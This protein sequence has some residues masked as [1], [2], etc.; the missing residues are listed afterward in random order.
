MKILHCSD[1]HLGKKPFGTKGFSQKRYLD[2]FKAFDEMAQIA[3]D[4]DVKLFI[5]AGDLF[6]KKELIPDTLERC[7]KTF[8]KLKNRDIKVFLIEGNHDNVTGNEEVNSWLGYLEKKG[9]VHRGKY[10]QVNREYSFEKF[11]VEDIN[12]YGLGY[13]GFAIDDVL[14]Q[15]AKSLDESEKNIVV[16]HT[17]LGGSEYL[18]GLAMAE[19]IRKLK[20]KVIYIAGGHLHSYQVY[21]KDEPYFF[22]PGSLEYWN[23]LNE[24][25]SNKGGIIFDTESREHRFVEVTPRKRM[26]LTFEYDGDIKEEFK[27]FCEELNLTGEELVILNVRV[28]ENGFIN[29]TELENILENSGALR[30]FIKLKYS[31]SSIGDIIEELGYY[32][33]KE[34]EKRIIEE[35]E[36]FRDSERTVEYL[37]KFKEYQ[38][39]SGRGEDFYNLFDRMLEEEIGIENK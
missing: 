1:I 5:V 16:V 31:D 25:S 38:E 11:V 21:P 36:E 10:S 34:A 19:S 13:P 28:R 2:F 12:I 33:I 24:K 17:A 35:W 37:Q 23:I 7:E 27:K 18:P 6:D 22:I 9:F 29:V 30:G 8:Q 4:E 32:S 3:I 39:E 26:E 14:E 15:L 20:D